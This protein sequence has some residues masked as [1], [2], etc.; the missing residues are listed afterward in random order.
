[1][2]V[3]RLLL[4]RSYAP[5]PDL[6]GHVFRHYVFHAQL[7]DDFL[8]I[9]KLMSEMAIIRILLQGDWA[10]ETGPGEW[11]TF[12]PILLMGSNS[13]PWRVRVRGPFLVVGVAFRPS[14]WAGLFTEPAREIADRA[15]PLP[16]FWGALSER[17]HHEVAAAND[18][19]RIVSVIE[20]VIRDRREA[21]GGPPPSAPMAAFEKIARNDSTIAVS[22][23]A[24]RVGLSVRQ[25]ERNCYASFGHSPKVILRRSRFLDMA[26]AMR[27]FSEP[28]AQQLAALRYFDQSHRN[29][30]FKHFFELTPG[31]F[32]KVTTPLFTAGLKL[33]ADGLA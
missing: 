22:E 13:T 9:D 11:S 10:A 31:Q 25:F 2:G 32:D 17:L 1:L 28:S 19:D 29:R 23:A 18:D 16:A 24:R 15:A 3:T 30:E 8:L 26:Q 14:G 6:A 7:P 12:G 27:G 33:R 5:S 21:L 4:S 20:A